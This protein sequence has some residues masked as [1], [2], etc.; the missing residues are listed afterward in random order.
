MDWGLDKLVGILK[1]LTHYVLNKKYF[2][3][4][5]M[6]K[7]V[8]KTVLVYREKSK[9]VSMET[10]WSPPSFLE[11]HNKTMY[12]EMVYKMEGLRLLSLHTR[13]FMLSTPPVSLVRIHCY[14]TRTMHEVF[15][16][17]PGLG[18]LDLFVFSAQVLRFGY[19]FNTC[20]KVLACVLDSD[21]FC[22][23]E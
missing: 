23:F 9:Q 6:H 19:D 2:Y 8:W 5:K 18:H 1:A 12:M 3:F 13:I 16:V 4:K 7:I 20:K 17:C 11:K 21:I 15:A 10:K 14:W 22:S